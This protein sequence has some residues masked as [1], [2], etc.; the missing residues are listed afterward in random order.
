MAQPPG[1]LMDTI[2]SPVTAASLLHQSAA[3]HLQPLVTLAQRNGTGRRYLLTLLASAAAI[4]EAGESRKALLQ[5]YVKKSK[6]NK[7]KNDKERLDDYYKRNYQDYFG[8][9]EG[10]VREKKE[11]ELTESEKGILA[12]LDKNK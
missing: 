10:S 3:K 4:P 8:F 6:E 1:K 5:D 9:M 12:W 7:E 11:E 2:R